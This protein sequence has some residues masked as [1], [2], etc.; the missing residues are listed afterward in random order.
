MILPGPLNPPRAPLIHTYYIQ[1]LARTHTHTDPTPHFWIFPPAGPGARVCVCD[2][3]DETLRNL[4][5]AWCAQ[6]RGGHST[7]I[8]I[9]VC[10]N[11]SYTTHHTVLVTTGD[12]CSPAFL[13]LPRY[14][15]ARPSRTVWSVCAR[16][17]CSAPVCIAIF[18]LLRPGL[19]LHP[20]LGRD[21][22][23][24]HCSLL[25]TTTYYF[26]IPL[27]A[28]LKLGAASPCSSIIT[29]RVTLHPA[30]LRFLHS[31]T[32]RSRPRPPAA[33]LLRSRTSSHVLTSA[34][35]LPLAPLILA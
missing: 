33:R 9:G 17:L 27:L 25:A 24:Y 16:R 13:P 5:Q 1:T 32:R 14:I 21:C 18:A 35:L 26:Q 19:C 22:R 12:A 8:A 6:P 2:E 7:P 20:G 23:G 30:C 15:S 29:S 11:T 34:V 31:N 28:L 3:V 10:G 4:Q